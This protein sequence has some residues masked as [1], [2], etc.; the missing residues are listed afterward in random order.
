MKT[1]NWETVANNLGGSVNRTRTPTGWLV[2]ITEDKLTV[3]DST[4]TTGHE[5]T[6]A[7]TFVP[8]P[9]GI[10]LLEGE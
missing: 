1:I 4:P 3:W 10:W 9:E 5:W 6:G 2:Y 7:L 8:D